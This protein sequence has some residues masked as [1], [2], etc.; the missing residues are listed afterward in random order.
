MP[1]CCSRRRCSGRWSSL[2]MW[3]ALSPC[4]KP[5]LMKGRRTLYSSSFV[6]KKA[7]TCRERPRAV[8][9]SRT[10]GF[11]LIVR[12]SHGRVARGHGPQLA[13]TN[14]TQVAPATR[15]QGLP[16]SPPSSLAVLDEGEHPV[17]PFIIQP[18]DQPEGVG[19]LETPAS[20]RLGDF[21]R[22][23]EEFLLVAVEGGGEPADQVF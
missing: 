2:T 19:A 6:W 9:A 16:N 3:N 4:S 21:L 15:R 14:R 11:S 8:P 18:G 23:Q 17:E 13:A 22:E 1:A 12:P 20:D 10:S 5:S 7:Q